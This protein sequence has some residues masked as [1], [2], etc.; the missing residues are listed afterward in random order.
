MMFK[1]IKRAAVGLLL[2]LF[3]LF[4]FAGLTTAQLQ[5]LKTAINNTPAWSAFP[6]NDDGHYAL[7]AELNKTASPSFPVWRTEAPIDAINDGIDY[8]KYTPSDAVPAS[9]PALSV[10]MA[11]LLRI[12]TKQMN[13]QNMLMGRTSLN[14][15]RANVRG[16][17][18]DAVIAVPA[19]VAGANTAPGGA[20]GVTVMTACTRSATYGEKVLAGAQETTGTVTANVL[21]FEGNLSP[22]DVQQARNLP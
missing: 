17:L 20:S 12:Q 21:G 14:C 2:S 9:D 1:T 19:G 16:G 18:R 13:L 5:T 8:S 3:S 4:A 7:A 15:S 22:S 6:N 10:D 11:R